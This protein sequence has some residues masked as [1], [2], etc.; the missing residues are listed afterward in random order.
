VTDSDGQPATTSSPPA[1]DAIKREGTI[2]TGAVAFDASHQGT[3]RIQISQNS[4]QVLLIRDLGS[5]FGSVLGV[6]FT[7]VGAAFGIGA[8]ALMLIISANHERKRRRLI[9]TGLVCRSPPARNDVVAGRPTAGHARDIR[10]MTSTGECST[11][12]M[13]ARHFTLMFSPEPSRLT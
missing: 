7:A 6:I 2:Y 5:P 3:Y 8:G 12:Q 11:S 10:A 9:V 13:Q 4:E 1:N